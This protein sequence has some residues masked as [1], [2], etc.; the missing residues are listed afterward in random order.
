MFY[1]E[2]CKKLCTMAPRL[3]APVLCNTQLAGLCP[4]RVRSLQKLFLVVNISPNCNDANM[5]LGGREEY[6]LSDMCVH[7]VQIELFE[8]V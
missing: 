3:T 5:Y 1:C 7:L 8:S 6:G 4:A 2:C